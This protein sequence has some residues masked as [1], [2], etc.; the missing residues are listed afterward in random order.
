[1]DRVKRFLNNPKDIKKEITKGFLLANQNLLHE[2]CDGNIIVANE[3]VE[4]KV[5]LLIGGGMGA[6]PHFMGYVGKNLADCAVVGN[7]YAAPPPK[8]ILEATRTINRKKGVLY[9]YNNYAGDNLSFDM[10]AELAEEEGIHTKTVR[11]SDNIGSIPYDQKSDRGGITGGILVV[12][13]A[14]G[15]SSIVNNLDEL[16]QIT[17]KAN[18]NTRSLITVA[19]S[20]SYL[21]SGELMFDLPEGKIEIGIGFQGEPGLLQSEMIPINEIVDYMLKIIFSDLPLSKN[22][23]VVLLLNNMGA[24]TLLELLIINNRIHQKLIENQILIH[25]N[26]IGNYYSSQEMYGFS[27]SLMKLDNEL[28]KFYDMPTNSFAFVKGVT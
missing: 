5:G 26:L 28:K 22:D 18:E 16:Y 20:G 10:A 11:I 21:D 1:M 6:E 9:L 19:K 3:L 23:E 17:K 24:I 14:G 7:F 4:N 25:D 2:I 12:K 27:I 13:V 15:A 8:I